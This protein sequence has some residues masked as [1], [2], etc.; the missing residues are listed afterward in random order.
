MS[1]IKELTEKININDEASRVEVFKALPEDLI[2][3]QEAFLKEHWNEII[4]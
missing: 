1:D 4:K 3:E 2:S